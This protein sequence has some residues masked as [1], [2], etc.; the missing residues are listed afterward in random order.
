MLAVLA[1][2]DAR[3]TL[4]AEVA[5]M[6]CFVQAD[7]DGLQSA[8]FQFGRGRGAW[9][10]NVHSAFSWIVPENLSGV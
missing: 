3:N 2:V 10:L 8:A 4:F 6:P 1:V 5:L 9:T 7:K